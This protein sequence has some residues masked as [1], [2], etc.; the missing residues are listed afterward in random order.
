MAA[1]FAAASSTPI[2][3][4]LMAVELLGAHALPHVALV[5]VLAWALVGPRSIYTAQRG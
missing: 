5:A 1:L 4:S 2:A 3:L